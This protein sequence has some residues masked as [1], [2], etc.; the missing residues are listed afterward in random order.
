MSTGGDAFCRVAEVGSLS[1]KA[2]MAIKTFFKRVFTFLA[3]QDS[4]IGDLVTHS[5]TQ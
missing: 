5:V 2:K 4:S 1:A 3:V